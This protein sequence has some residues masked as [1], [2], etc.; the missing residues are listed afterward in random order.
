MIVPACHIIASIYDGFLERPSCSISRGDEI[1]VG[2][3]G[4]TQIVPLCAWLPKEE[5]GGAAS[6]SSTPKMT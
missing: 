4:F 3:Q 5:S 2:V 1:C 6:V